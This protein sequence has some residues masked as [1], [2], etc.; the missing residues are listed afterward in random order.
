[1]STAVPAQASAAVLQPSEPISDSAIS[2]QGPDLE[3]NLSLQD[4]LKSYERIGFQASSLGRAIDIVN[5]M[6]CFLIFQSLCDA[7]SIQLRLAEMAPI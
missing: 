3:K 5:R 4:L 1:M 6:V 7:L 2:V